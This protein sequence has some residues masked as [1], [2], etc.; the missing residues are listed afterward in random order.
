MMMRRRWRGRGGIRGD[1]GQHG[2]GG[3][4]DGQIPFA[5]FSTCLHVGRDYVCP[6]Y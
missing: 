5:S 2:G 3:G 6:R 4:H 1:V